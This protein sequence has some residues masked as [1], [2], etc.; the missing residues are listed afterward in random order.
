[1]LAG[2]GEELLFRGVIQ[3]WLVSETNLWLGLAVTSILFGLAHFISRTYA[4]YA[5]VVGAYLGWLFIAFDNL[6][7]PILTHAAYD[8]FA[9][10]YLVRLRPVSSPK[11]T[12]PLEPDC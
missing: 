1:M 4:V 2:L 7:V 11:D 8:F 5:A 12:S 10:V 9:L 6:L 3:S